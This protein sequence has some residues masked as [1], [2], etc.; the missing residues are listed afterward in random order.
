MPLNTD[1]AMGFRMPQIESPL[2]QAGQYMTLK[3]AML[4]Q[5][6]AEQSRRDE[7][8]LSGVMQQTQGDPQKAIQAL[9]AHGSPTAIGLA[10]KLDGLIKKPDAGFTLSPGAVRYGPDGKVIARA[11]AALER[12]RAQPEIINLQRALDTLPPGSPYR[13]QIEARIK[14]LNAPPAGVTVNMPSSTQTMVGQDGRFYQFRVGKDGTT[15]AIAIAD[16]DGK[17][18]SPIPTAAQSKDERDAQEGVQTVASVR[19]RIAKMAQLI[20]GGAMAG[21]VVGPAGIASRVGE[22]AAGV[23]NPAIQTPALDYDNE[24]NL[25]LAEVRK[26]VEKDQN[27]SNEERATL[28]KTL[29]GGTLQ[30]S[31]SALRTLS[32][33]LNYVENKRLTGKGR[34][35]TLESSVRAAGWAFEPDKYDY[36]VV[37]GKV[38]RKAK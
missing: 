31:G 30:T 38:Q 13:A 9:L 11:P 22:T 8:I 34:A 18:L 26:M 14:H 36:R 15:E 27:L 1:I 24:K 28:Q 21:G 10:A 25:L 3:N 32:N 19:Q 33:V 12:E 16:K 2:Q 37:E 5:Q 17:P 23:V 35:A 4:Q 20:H 6:Q 29:G 7:A